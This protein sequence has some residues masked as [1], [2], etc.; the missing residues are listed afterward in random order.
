M[1]M[2]GSYEA[3]GGSLSAVHLYAGRGMDNGGIVGDGVVFC[4]CMETGQGGRGDAKSVL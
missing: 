4:S 1:S 2:L 3:G